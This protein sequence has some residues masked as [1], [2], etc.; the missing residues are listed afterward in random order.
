MNT[1]G[2]LLVIVAFALGA[3][4]AG[5]IGVRVI[6]EVETT[7]DATSLP[8][9]ATTTT[10]ANSDPVDTYQVD[11]YET[12]ISSTALVPTS[13]E[14]A[15]TDLSIGYDLVSLAPHGGVAPISFVGGFGVI[16]VV[17]NQDLDHVY[18]R[19]WVV[20]AGSQR[21]T[22][23]PS[24]SSTRFAR[25]D[26]DEGFSISEITRVTITDALAPY[27]LDVPFTVSEAQP[28]AD[29]APGVT[30]ELLNTSDQGTS[31]IVQVA[32]DLDD[33]ELAG[34]FVVGDGPGWRSSFFE[35]EGRPR[36][37]LT[38]VGGELPTEIPLR[39]QGSIMVPI[40]GDFDVSL[41]G[42]S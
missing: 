12:L 35:A 15:G 28:T 40:T 11:P 8:T 20:E 34:F 1:R 14:S 6:R 5:S 10:V 41:E 39:A 30:V 16:T 19:E 36:V 7:E 38:W 26:V 22:G 37:N 2:I 18:P 25:F 17:E 21:F 27:A 3:L 13:I 9:E 4:A 24:S 31:T 23:G 42:L 32:I 33:P 29:V